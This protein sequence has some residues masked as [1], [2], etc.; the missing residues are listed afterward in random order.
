MH[1]MLDDN[2]GLTGN[3]PRG[4]SGDVPSVTSLW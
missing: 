3:W 1:E 2:I 4:A